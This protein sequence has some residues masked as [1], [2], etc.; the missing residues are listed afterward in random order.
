MNVHL[1]TIAVISSLL[2]ATL[3][4]NKFQGEQ[5]NV[6]RFCDFFYFFLFYQYDFVVGLSQGFVIKGDIKFNFSK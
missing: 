3:W 2:V 1:E 4:M 6:T 5:K